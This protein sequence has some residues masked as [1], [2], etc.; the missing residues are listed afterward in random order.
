MASFYEL[1]NVDDWFS[2]DQ[3]NDSSEYVCSNFEESDKL[4]C[5]F[6]FS[7]GQKREE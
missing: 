5:E 3:F 7:T 6:S 4:I 2:A 1:Q